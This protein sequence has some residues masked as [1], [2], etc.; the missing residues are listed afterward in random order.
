MTRKRKI[1]VLA[2]LAIFI[3]AFIITVNI[4]IA[5]VNYNIPDGVIKI[6]AAVGIIGGLIGAVKL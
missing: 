5:L 4:G 3:I 6:I 1:I 2:V